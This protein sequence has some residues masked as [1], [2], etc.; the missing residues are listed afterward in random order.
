MPGL[1]RQAAGTFSVPARVLLCCLVCAVGLLALS[2][3]AAT[4][5][6]KRPV[7]RHHRQHHVA[8][9]HGSHH[10]LLVRR[11]HRYAL[12][13][14]R[15]ARRARL[16]RRRNRVVRVARHAL[17]VPYRW[18]GGSP[19]TGF[20]C[21]GLTRW[22]YSNVGVSLPHYS[23]AQW[24]YGRPVARRALAPGLL[25][26]SGLGHVGIYV[27]HGAL[28]HAT[29]AGARVRVE[30]LSGWLASSYDGARRLRLFG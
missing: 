22:V 15:R 21:S 8:R 3:A 20:D 28:I 13:H 19:R 10:R 7:K 24:R 25:F 17:G 6:P 1:L 16:H 30:R 14:A 4:A 23:V 9:R 18:A 27:G 26:F 12:L 5:K 29:H 2:S 11:Q